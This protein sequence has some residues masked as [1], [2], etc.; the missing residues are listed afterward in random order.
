[1]ADALRVLNAW[2]KFSFRLPQE[3]VDVNRLS[4]NDCSTANGA[5][6]KGLLDAEPR[7]SRAIVST[8][9]KYIPIDQSNHRIVGTAYAR[10][11]F[12]NRVQHGLDIRGRAGNYA[13][14]LTRRRLLFQRFLELF[15]QPDVLNRD[16]G[17]VGEGL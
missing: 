17:L 1:M 7:L 8:Q 10:G 12:S 15:E 9:S 14:N 4:I 6:D 16:H 2:G 3:I 5:S 11:I 13:E